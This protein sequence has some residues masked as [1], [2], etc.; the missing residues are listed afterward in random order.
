MAVPELARRKLYDDCED[1][2][3][4]AWENDT[5]DRLLGALNFCFLQKWFWD[6]LRGS[7]MM[8][9]HAHVVETNSNGFWIERLHA[10]INKTKPWRRGGRKGQGLRKPKTTDLAKID[11]GFLH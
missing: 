4:N 3:R 8:T 6:Y 9:G 2:Y 1:I 11:A 7:E 10:K 5:G